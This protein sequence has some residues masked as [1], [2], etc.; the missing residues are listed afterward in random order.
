MLVRGAIGFLLLLILGYGLLKA[1]PLLAGPQL[2]I[3]SPAEGATVADGFLTVAGTV[4]Y[5]ETLAV[6]GARLLID[7]HGRFTDTLTLPYGNAILLLSA[8]DRFGRRVTE[9]RTVYVPE[10]N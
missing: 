2:F 4:R 9:T 5:G 7:E 1:Y 6:N 8:S 3:E 10:P